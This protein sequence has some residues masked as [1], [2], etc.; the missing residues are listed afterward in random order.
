[1]HPIAVQSAHVLRYLAA[2]GPTSLAAIAEGT[3]KDKANTRRS[4]LALEREGFVDKG[5]KIANTEAGRR[6]ITALDV[7]EGA[8]EIPEDYIGIL[9]ENLREDPDNARQTFDDESI[10]EL[11]EDLRRRGLLQNLIVRPVNDD[12]TY[13]LRGGARR[14]RAIGRCI[15]RG[16]WSATRRIICQVRAPLD[17]IGSIVEGLV[18]NLQRENLPPI[19]EARKFKVL[20]DKGL[21]TAGIAKEVSKSR[22]YVQL[23]LDLLNLP[24]QA[25]EAIRTGEA[26][27]EDGKRLRR[28]FKASP[29]I[30]ARVESGEILVDEAVELAKREQPSEDELPLGDGKGRKEQEPDA[31]GADARLNPEEAL[32]LVELGDRARAGQLSDFKRGEFRLTTQFAPSTAPGPQLALK[33][34]IHLGLLGFSYPSGG[35]CFAMVTESA[36]EWLRRRNLLTTRETR[37]QIL[38]LATRAAL[39]EAGRAIRE[40]GHYSTSWLNDAAPV[41]NTTEPEQAAL[42]AIEAEA[43]VGEPTVELDPDD[44]PS[45]LGAAE[46]AGFK[47]V[48][49]HDP[50]HEIIKRLVPIGRT[51]IGALKNVEGGIVTH[52]DIE[53]AREILAKFEPLIA[54]AAMF[55]REEKAA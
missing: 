15:E 2:A 23:R 36:V 50:F 30:L 45:T 40:A 28:F 4:V 54:D 11:A 18:E 6:A 16:W 13:T 8:I 3:G 9:Y 25:I 37:D 32:I 31:R 7:A 26:S 49:E 29:E 5:E 53:T 17:E 14:K 24:T 33:R 55:V 34:L 52:A 19:D 21:D 39:G 12:G 41:V 44:T 35:G 51:A 46:A 27:A 48:R 10:D 1:M 47:I 42:F 38:D 20:L 22:R 43:A